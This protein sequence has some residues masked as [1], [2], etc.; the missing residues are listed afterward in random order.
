MRKLAYDWKNGNE[1]EIGMA[2][3][4]IISI[5]YDNLIA[6]LFE[7]FKDEI[8]ICLHQKCVL[9]RLFYLLNM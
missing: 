2:I 1:F 4:L 6:S 7:S 3:Y 8:N 9:Y 5:F